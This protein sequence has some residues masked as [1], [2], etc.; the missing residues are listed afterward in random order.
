MG[1]TGLP[2]LL[3]LPLALGQGADTG[4]NQLLAFLGNAMNSTTAWGLQQG[5]N[6]RN[7]NFADSSFGANTQQ[8][9][10]NVGN[11]LNRYNTLADQ[12]IAGNQGLYN[13]VTG[14]LGALHGRSMGYLQGQGAQERADI[15]RGFD[16]QGSANLA[17]LTS[18][19]LANT[20]LLPGMQSLN[21][22]N[23]F[24]ALGGLSE[25]LNQQYLGTDMNTTGMLANAQSGLGQW[26]QG[27]AQNLRF[28]GNSDAFNMN[29]GLAQSRLYNQGA[30]NS[31]YQGNTQGLMNL[32]NQTNVNYPDAG[33][34]AQLAGNLGTGPG[35]AA[36][37]P[38]PNTFWDQA[39]APAAGILGGSAAVGGAGFLYGLGS[40]LI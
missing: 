11:Y 14:G 6:K 31:V 38:P 23:R 18:R 37:K 17:D 3:N 21:Q 2:D 33:L 9:E 7:E 32:L 20:S 8:Q 1:M 15:N 24:D 27:N 30:A 16:A 5:Q 29:Q 10:Q 4:I 19:G 34:S 22:R 12:A 39:L 35:M 26:A 28:G 13:Q 36:G 25:R 40:T